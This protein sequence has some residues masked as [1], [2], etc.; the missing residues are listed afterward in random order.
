MIKQWGSLVLGM[1]ILVSPW[2]LGFSA[3]SL[4]KWSN[5]ICGT[6]IILIAVWDIFGER[7]VL[8]GDSPKNQ[9]AAKVS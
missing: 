9:K 1:W 5:V 2:L 4:M 8:E 7:S 6:I 3:I